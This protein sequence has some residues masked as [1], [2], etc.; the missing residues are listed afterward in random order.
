MRTVLCSVAVAAALTAAPAAAA[1]GSVTSALGGLRRSGAITAT[2]YA[3]DLAT[4]V[5]AQRALGRLAGTRRTE[6]GAVLENVRAITAAG[7]LTPS[8]LPAL[9]LT[10]ERN[11]QWWTR[12]QLL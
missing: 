5:S 7:G 6:L 9:F 11:R 3:R 4:Y 12:E 10:L 1:R 2:T 8:R